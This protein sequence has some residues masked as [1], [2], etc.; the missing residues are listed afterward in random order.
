[1]PITQ[2]GRGKAQFVG[3]GVSSQSKCSCWW[4]SEL[5]S[6]CH[7]AKLP[8]RNLRDYL[9]PLFFCVS[10]NWQKFDSSLSKEREQ[11]AWNHAT[12]NGKL[13]T[14]THLLPPGPLLLFLQLFLHLLWGPESNSSMLPYLIT[15][16]T[17]YNTGIREQLRV[18]VWEDNPSTPLWWNIHGSTLWIPDVELWHHTHLVWV[19][20]LTLLLA[21]VSQSLEQC[22]IEES[23]G[24]NCLN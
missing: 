4:I 7:R 10:R 2:P 12:F 23:S 11:V 14:R 5:A 6:S 1:M 24:E 3:C 18:Q 9:I 20:K 17:V 16:P 8:V 15:R 19:Q 13:H 22:Q 21:F